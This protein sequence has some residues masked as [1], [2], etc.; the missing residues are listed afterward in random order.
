MNR[1]YVVEPMPTPTGREGRPSV[2]AAR[3]RHGG[4]RLGAGHR[5]R[6]RRKGAEKGDNGDIYNWI[7]T[8]GARPAAQ[9]GRQPGHRRASISRPSSTRWRTP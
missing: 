4:V 6:S 8:I 5:G 7:G 2:A 3:R 9:Q 1:L